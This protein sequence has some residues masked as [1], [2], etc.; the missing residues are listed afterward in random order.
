MD[1]GT[2]TIDSIPIVGS[3]NADNQSFWFSRELNVAI[4][5]RSEGEKIRASF[6]D[7]AWDKGIKMSNRRDKGLTVYLILLC[8]ISSSVPETDTS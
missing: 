4:C 6:F 3:Q 7:D 8:R 1:R 2:I 5:S